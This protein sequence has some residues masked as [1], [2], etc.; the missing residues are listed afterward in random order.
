MTLHKKKLSIVCFALF[1]LTLNFAGQ[2]LPLYIL[3]CYIFPIFFLLQSQKLPKSSCLVCIFLCFA[4]YLAILYLNGEVYRSTIIMTIAYPFA[5]LLGILCIRSA[6]SKTVSEL[7]IFKKVVFSAAFGL[8]IHNVL[9]YSTGAVMT[10]NI[11]ESRYVA[12]FWTGELIFPTNFNN[13]NVF[14]LC[15]LFFCLHC[16]DS[17]IEKIIILA[18]EALVLYYSVNTAS[19]TN[20]VLMALIY[21]VTWVYWKTSV[22]KC[23]PRSPVNKNQKWTGILVVLCAII[24]VVYK[25]NTLVQWYNTSNLIARASLSTKGNYDL[26]NDGRLA[27]WAEVI[28]KMPQYPFGNMPTTNYAHNIFL[29]TYRV[30]GIIPMSLLIISMVCIFI[31]LLKF[32]RLPFVDRKYKCLAFS[33]MTGSF[34]SFMIE[35]VIEG[36][37]LLLLVFFLIAGMIEEL[38]KHCTTQT[39]IRR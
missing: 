27:L 9:S 37:P 24:L 10:G 32:L 25:W 13:M 6:N 36:R 19:R 14:V 7:M 35:P 21:I 12:D 11:F 30:A 17:L 18:S 8:F 29:D 22:P 33:V 26:S 16:S 31:F 23:R 34:C 38:A 5:Y 28:R 39:Q 2:T 1:L 4:F 15:L 20:I 3:T